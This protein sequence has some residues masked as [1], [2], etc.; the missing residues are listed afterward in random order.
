VSASV[1]APS[2][3]SRRG[4]PFSETLRA[5]RSGLSGRE[6]LALA[7]LTLLAAA[8]RFYGIGH[9][10]FW[11]DEGDT[12]LLLKF[13]PGEMLALIPKTESTPPLYYGIAW[14]WVRIF[15]DD[16]AGLRSLSALC[17]VLVVPVAWAAARKLVGDWAGPSAGA[18]A[19]LITAALTAC[20]PFL[21]WYSQEGR[22]YEMLVLFSALSLLA[23]AWLRAA[24]SP[25]LAALWAL[26][27]AL[28]MW[29]HY[30]GVVVAVPEAAWLLWEH[31][32][33]ERCI[34]AAIGAVA[35]SGLVLV[36]LIVVQNSTGNDIW[37]AHSSLSLRLSQILPQ[38]ILGTGTP[39]RTPLKFIG[40]ALCL[41]A[42]GLLAG[43]GRGRRNGALLA[44]GLALGGFVLTMLF[45]A[46]GSDTLITRNIINLWLPA[47]ILVAGGPA[48]SGHRRL[49]MAVTAGLCA[50]GLI[51]IVGV[52]SDYQLQRPNWG[53]VARALG[54]RPVAGSSRIIL[55]Q[56]YKTL[57][58][59]SLY[60]SHLHFLR[61]VHAS[62]TGIREIDI[63]SIRS[64]HDP[65]CWWGAACNLKPTVMQRSYP[66]RGFREVSLRHVE[67]FT[68]MRLEARRPE[69]VTRAMVVAALSRT[70]LRKD[71]FLIQRFAAG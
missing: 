33:R 64:P 32:G 53:P 19:G 5:V 4:A 34:L 61:G 35:L 63:I 39:L 65:L 18:R 25:R 45:V 46:A 24:P 31:R 51:A 3:G 13:T 49:G 29:T 50:I 27:C 52:Q 42:V 47:A 59:L 10:G 67:Q 70:R 30:Y 17:G 56:H 6:G 36:P 40:F 44:G 57:L 37:I 55:I 11:F 1:A 60:M 58:P 71:G 16:E 43:S 62:A 14:F 26:A 66:I 54:P 7:A 8:L 22:S 15:G 69:R 12:A 2:E 21:V 48:L 28:A 9:Q 38:F 20:N 23:F 68:I 41:L